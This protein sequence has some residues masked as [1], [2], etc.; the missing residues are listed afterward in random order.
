M[1]K[2]INN[3]RELIEYF[4]RPEVEFR[5]IQQICNTSLCLFFINDYNKEEAIKAI[6]DYWNKWKHTKERPLFI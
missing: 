4:N 2:E 6:I 3:F 5:H 1:K